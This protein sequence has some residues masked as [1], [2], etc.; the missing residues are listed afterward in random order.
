MTVLNQALAQQVLDLVD[1]IPRGRV[2]S[3]GQIA[4]LVGRPRNA[5][6]VAK[7]ISQAERYGGHHP[8]HR[9]V[10]AA[11]RLAPVWLDQEALLWAEGVD[12]KK[13]GVVDMKLYQWEK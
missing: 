1:R 8:C 5:R 7:I 2:A 4:R 3:Y 11:G 9:V 12:C 10:N 6:L 13:P